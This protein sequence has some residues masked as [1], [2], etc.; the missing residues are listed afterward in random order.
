MESWGYAQVSNVVGDP[1]D[2]VMSSAMGIACASTAPTAIAPMYEVIKLLP[3]QR[4]S[5]PF[6]QGSLLLRTPDEKFGPI[7]REQV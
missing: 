4:P 7:K 2:C 5:S 6:D 3:W 1:L